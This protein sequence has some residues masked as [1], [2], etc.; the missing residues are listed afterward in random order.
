MPDPN[1]FRD[2]IPLPQLKGRGAAINPGN[3]FEGGHGMGD[4]GESVRRLHVLGDYLD[5]VIAEQ[6]DGTRIATMIYRDRTR[7]VINRVDSPDLGFEWTINPYRGCEHGCIYCYARPGHEYLGL[8]C[9]LDF[10]TKILVKENA[11]SLLREELLSPKWMGERIVLSGVT[12][13]YQPAEA[14]LGITRGILEV[15]A[16]FAQPVSLI[17]K[18]AMMLR[19]I[20]LLREINATSR[21]RCCVSLTTLDNRLSAAMEPRASSPQA[22]LGLIRGLADAGINVTV[23]TA[24]IIPGLNDVEIP[25]L[26]KAARDAGATSAG[27]VLLR[28][29]NQIKAVFL[30]WLSRHFPDRAAKVENALRDMRGGELYESSYFARQRGSG[31]RADHIRSTF[32]VFSKRLGYTTFRTHGTGTPDNAEFLRR[33]DM[34]RQDRDE[35]GQQLLFG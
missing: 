25:A 15:C 29:P 17:T 20:D 34:L 19:D 27:W 22:R 12:D 6:P 31:P 30:E 28:L 10:E 33:R 35:P 24:P 3:R 11:P 5:E 23:M 9:G 26:L 18:N 4:G 14:R 32:D 7:S 2:A 21:V 16:R 1:E 13:P 8:S